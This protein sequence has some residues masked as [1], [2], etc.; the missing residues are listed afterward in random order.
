MEDPYGTQTPDWGALADA[1][2]ARARR[3][4]WLLIGGGVLATGA[5][6]AVVATTVVSVNKG[7]A[8]ASQ[9]Q[10]NQLPP[11]S[12][13]PTGTTE[14]EPAFS[15]VAPPPPPNPKDFVSSADKDKA[16]LSAETLFPGDKLTVADRAYRKGATTATTNCA[17][18]AQG[19]LGS[20]L[21]SN[22]C[23]QVIRATFSK[24]GVAV[25]VGVAVFEKETQA[26]KAK[27]QAE[28]G[29]ASLSG[30]GVPTFCR[31]PSVCRKTANSYG[32]YVYFT[33]GGFISGQNATKADKNVFD[34]GDDVAEFTFQQILARGQAQAS[35]AATRPVDR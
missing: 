14:P 35:A 6:A 16:P 8:N 28:G 17:A 4:R 12:E 15:S 30:A 11:V 3:K 19:A 26:L 21:A 9:G 33:V 34:A 2:A 18:A 24:D 1:S 31:A 32:R 29:I 5:I 10:A 20:I 13:L 23:D 25:T 22:S 7:D 27:E